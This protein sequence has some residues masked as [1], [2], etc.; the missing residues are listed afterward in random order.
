MSADENPDWSAI[1]GD[2][3]FISDTGAEMRATRGGAQISVGRYAVWAPLSSGNGE[4]GG[5]GGHRVVE[6]SSSLSALMAKYGVP[7]DRVL[8]LAVPEKRD[9]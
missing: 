9:V 5:A 7:A 1:A 8:S 4:N 6:V 2:K 3:T